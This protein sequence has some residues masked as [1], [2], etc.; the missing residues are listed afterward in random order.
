MALMSQAA[1]IAAGFGSALIQF[2]RAPMFA[3]KPESAVAGNTRT[4]AFGADAAIRA[5]NASERSLAQSSSGPAS[6]NP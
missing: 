5:Q 4:S 1:M 3:S 2:T 6:T